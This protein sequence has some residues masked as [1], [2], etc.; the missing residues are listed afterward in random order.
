MDLSQSIPENLW[1]YEQTLPK[2]S[3]QLTELKLYINSMERCLSIVDIISARREDHQ[4]NNLI[5]FDNNFNNEIIYKLQKNLTRLKPSHKNRAIYN[6]NKTIFL[7]MS[8]SKNTW[9]VSSEKTT[10]YPAD[11]TIPKPSAPSV[12]KH[13]F[14]NTLQAMID[15]YSEQLK[16]LKQL[17]EKT[18]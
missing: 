11:Q 17:R 5:K 9:S 7:N 16:E 8:P 4:W 10:P 13:Y 18:T 3:L 6:H 14:E 2:K 15:Q 12:S 1:G